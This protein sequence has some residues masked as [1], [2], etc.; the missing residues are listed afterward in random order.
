MSDFPNAWYSSRVLDP[1]SLNSNDPVKFTIVIF[2]LCAMGIPSVLEH[3]AV[4]REERTVVLLHGLARSSSTMERMQT[5][6]MRA[7]FQTCNIGYPSRHHLV[8]A[9][10][11]E[12]I[13]PQ[14]QTCLDGSDSPVDFVTHSLGGILVR[15]LSE[16]GLVPR[17][18]RVVMLSPPNRGSE[19]VDKLGGNWLFRWINGPAGGELGTSESSLPATL[20]PPDFE[21]GIITGSRSINPILS[22]LIE[23]KDDGKVS[24]ERAKLS[25]MNGF[26]VLPSAHPFIMKNETVIRQTVHFLKTGAF[27]AG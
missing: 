26:L 5:A 2:F 25:G 8:E 15:Y 13:L 24:I 23:G 6:L 12:Y 22:M 3:S 9:L 7:G 14:I 10:A 4:P 21:V 20:G 17:I 1:R 19:V 16:Q 11:Q 18:G 27:F